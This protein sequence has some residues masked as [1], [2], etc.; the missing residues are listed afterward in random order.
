MIL[1]KSSVVSIVLCGSLSV[2]SFQHIVCYI[3]AWTVLRQ[4]IRI[5]SRCAHHCRWAV[6]SGVPLNDPYVFFG[7][8]CT[9]LPYRA[10]H[11][12]WRREVVEYLVR[13]GVPPI[14]IS[15]CTHPSNLYFALEVDSPRLRH[16]SQLF[17]SPTTLSFLQLSLSPHQHQDHHLPSFYFTP[18]SSMSLHSTPFPLL[19]QT[20]C[21]QSTKHGKPPL[22]VSLNR[23]QPTSTSTLVHHAQ[24]WTSQR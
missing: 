5:D 9:Q 11:Y 6:D 20:N 15:G 8:I 2:E 21:H 17:T 18:R 12:Y 23:L 22:T 19:Q 24:Q 16:H 1:D 7:R 3:I 13:S 10:R 4:A 14:S